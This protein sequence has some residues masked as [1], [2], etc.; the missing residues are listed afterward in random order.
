MIESKLTVKQR[1]FADAYIEIGNATEA[2]LKAYPNV[3][4]EATARAAGSRMLT[5]VSVKSYIDSRMEELKS[6]KVA[7]QQEIL[8]LLTAIARGET[9]S[10]TLRGI[11]EGAQTIDEDMP[12]TTAE[13]IKAAELLGKRY[14]MWTEKV[15]VEHSG[16]IESRLDLSRL[17]DEELRALANSIK[18]TD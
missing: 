18:K 9:T 13:R 10:A 6:Q 14:R 4:K 2:Y 8:E 17:T 3:K 1:A 7:D 5:N 12:P 16:E 15:D 11:G